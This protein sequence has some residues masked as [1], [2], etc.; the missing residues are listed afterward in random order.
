[1]GGYRE[2]YKEVDK[3]F[4]KMFIRRFI[5]V[6]GSLYKVNKESIRVQNHTE[7]RLQIRLPEEDWRMEAGGFP[8]FPEMHLQI[9]FSIRGMEDGG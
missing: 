9:C 2:V 3:G 4:I 1:M 6:N 8:K 5:G 7:V